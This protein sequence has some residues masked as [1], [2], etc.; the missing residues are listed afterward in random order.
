M[1][2]EEIAIVTPAASG[3]AEEEFKAAKFACVEHIFAIQVAVIAAIHAAPFAVDEITE[4]IGNMNDCDLGRVDGEGILEQFAILRDG[5][6]A[7]G[8]DGPDRIDPVMRGACHI[9]FAGR[10]C[11]LELRSQWEKCLCCQK[12]IEPVGQPFFGR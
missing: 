2:G 8:D 11:H 1:I 5:A 7:L 9:V 6:H 4:R 3:L 12:A 10:S